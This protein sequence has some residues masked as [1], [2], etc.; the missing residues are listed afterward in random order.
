MIVMAWDRAHG[1]RPRFLFLV[2]RGDVAVRLLFSL[3]IC[4]FRGFGPQSASIGHC[5]EKGKGGG[6][7]TQMAEVRKGEVCLAI[8]VGR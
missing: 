2:L 7:P 4:P 3:V 8:R 1:F 6:P 5:T